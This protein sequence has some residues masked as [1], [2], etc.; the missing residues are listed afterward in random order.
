VAFSLVGEALPLDAHELN[1][2]FGGLATA[3]I[4]VDG[5]M[6]DELVAISGSTHATGDLRIFVAGLDDDDRWS[7]G[8]P[9][10]IPNAGHMGLPVATGDPRHAWL[11]AGPRAPA[12]CR[13]R[14][15]GAPSLVL[16]VLERRPCS[17]LDPEVGILEEPVTV[18]YLLGADELDAIRRG[19]APSLPPE[20][21]LGPPAGEAIVGFT[22]FNGDGDSDDELALLLLNA[23][24]STCASRL[25]DDLD[26][27]LSARVAVLDW[28]G[29]AWSAPLTYAA[30]TESDV[31]SL[32]LA[33]V[34]VAPVTGLAAGDANGDGVDDLVLGAVG[35]SVVLKGR[36]V[37]P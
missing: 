16:G 12:V 1:A 37:N 2:S 35:S 24:V 36:P 3:V 20:A 5:D 34:G 19:D 21:R 25:D 26:V 10:S 15:D 31:E 23:P 22:C 13:F 28:N 11:D 14:R 27:T 4:D 8:P 18:L 6:R 32:S 30:L 33:V 7:G 9:L 29:S 17:A